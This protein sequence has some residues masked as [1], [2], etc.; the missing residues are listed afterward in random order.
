MRFALV[1]TLLSCVAFSTAHIIGISGPATYAPGP[2]SKYP[3]KF[4]TEDGPITKY[5]QP[6]FISRQGRCN[7]EC[8]VQR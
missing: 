3:L 8:L 7:V 6:P 5:A 4:T 1:A 2:N